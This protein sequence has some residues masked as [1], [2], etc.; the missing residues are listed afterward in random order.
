MIPLI[1]CMFILLVFFVY[2]ML[3]MVVQQGIMVK[4]PV[5]ATATDTA[6]DPIVISITHDGQFLINKDVVDR[7]TFGLRLEAHAGE[8]EHPTVVINA[9]AEAEHGWVTWVMGEVR[10]HGIYR[11]M[12]LSNDSP[13]N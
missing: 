1:D 3:S 2:S 12:I 11:V 10:N 8:M 13:A 5:A 6:E 7:D 4:L 9:D